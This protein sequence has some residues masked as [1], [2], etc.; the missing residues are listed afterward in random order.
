MEIIHERVENIVDK[1]E[2]AGHNIITN[3]G[4]YS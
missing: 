3:N 1:E 4:N 2:N